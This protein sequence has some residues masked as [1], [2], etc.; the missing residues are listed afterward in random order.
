[1]TDQASEATAANPAP[2]DDWSQ[3]MALSQD[4][5]QA[6][7]R[8]LLK[9]IT[10]Y[11][12]ALARRAGLPPDDCEDGVQDV[13]MTIHVIRHT[14][15][16][17]RP[18]TPWLVGVARNRLA[19]KRRG[20][21]RVWARETE[22]TVEHETFVAAETK[23][24]EEAED[25]RRLHAAVAELPA[26]QRQ[27]VELLKLKELSLKEASAATGQSETALK[28]AVHRAVKRLRVILGDEDR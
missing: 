13:L 7:Y 5:D 25:A 18:F 26:G 9:S 1:M 19:D 14:Y 10:P 16:P 21:A 8:K 17:T 24:I 6:A 27:A 23:G 22:L 15:D 11:L 3:L 20:R 28:V 4:G 2:R 12:R